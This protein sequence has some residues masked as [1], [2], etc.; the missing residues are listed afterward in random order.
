MRGLI[1]GLGLALGVAVAPAHATLTMVTDRG[2]LGA[3]DTVD[4]AQLGPAGAHLFTPVFATSSGGGVTVDV[5]SPPGEVFRHDQSVD[6][7]GNFAPGAALVFEQHELE[8]LQLSFAAPV[9]GAGAQIQESLLRDFTATIRAFSPTDAPLGSFTVAGLATDAA[10][11]SAPFLGVLSDTPI[12]RIV[13]DTVGPGGAV[14]DGF[15]VNALALV[16]VPEPASLTLLA[17]ALALTAAWRRR[18]A[19]VSS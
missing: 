17:G 11:D 5:S 16:E 4:W 1:G 13:F 15:A 10:D 6:W 3:T 12:G 14:D 7:T 18:M 8:P 19:R 9:L 2:A